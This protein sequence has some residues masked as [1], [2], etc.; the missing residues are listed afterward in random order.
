MELT[1]ISPMVAVSPQIAA[2]DMPAGYR[3]VI[4]NRP[5]GEGADQQ[6]YEKIDAAAKA[7]GIEARYLP[8]TSGMLTDRDV[9]DFS[10]AL[11]QVQGPVLAYCRTGTRSATLWSL[12]E[13]KDSP[14]PRSCPRP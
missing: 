14:V 12:H 11:E 7:A 9:A 4:C 2:A 13:A 5:D 10:M 6:S 8:V 1:K 3:A